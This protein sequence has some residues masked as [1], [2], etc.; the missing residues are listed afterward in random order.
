MPRQVISPPAGRCAIALDRAWYCESCSVICNDA[1]CCNCD[2]SEHT[3]RLAPWLDR[4]SEPISI[5]PTGVF[6]TV[7]PASKKR[8]EAECTPQQQRA[9]RA[10]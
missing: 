6:L 9:P 7:I 2:S 3:H 1:T 10:S 4:E 8:P 5:P